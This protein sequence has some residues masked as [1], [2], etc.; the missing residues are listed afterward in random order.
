MPGCGVGLRSL[1]YP[2][3]LENWPKAPWFEAV[4]ENY[5][6]SGGRPLHILEKVR[7]RYPV[8]LHGV[9][10]SIGSIDP[11]NAQYLERLK[12]LAHRIDPFIVSD[13]LCWSGVGGRHLHDLLPLPFTEESIAHVVS[14]VGQVQELLGRP[15]LLE[16]ASTYV[17]FKHS[18]ISEWEFLRE[19][20]RRSGCGILLDLN[21]IF[22]NSVNHRF[23]PMRYLEEIPGK[24]VGPVG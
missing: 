4:T 7:E 8:A 23:D 20:A 3:I 22:V 11:L 19:I 6:D 14:H 10:L 5:M 24:W 15:I 13:H 17:T 21:N 1:H 2:H 9:A 16:N 12:A 18:V